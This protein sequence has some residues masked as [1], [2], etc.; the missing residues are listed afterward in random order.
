[1]ICSRVLVVV[2]IGCSGARGGGRVTGCSGA[3]GGGR[4]TGCSGARR[5]CGSCEDR[6]VAVARLLARWPQRMQLRE[7]L[8]SFGIRREGMIYLPLA[9]L[10]VVL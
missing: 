5:R 4:V 6:C 1:M 10:L 8:G 7:D 3:R 9:R 2:V